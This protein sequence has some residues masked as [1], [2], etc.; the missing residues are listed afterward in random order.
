MNKENTK[1]FACDGKEELPKFDTIEE[2][3]R[4]QERDIMMRRAEVAASIRNDEQQKK[5]QSSR[6]SV[7]Y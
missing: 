2:L 3:V 4:A 5:A 1:L 7:S 6:Q